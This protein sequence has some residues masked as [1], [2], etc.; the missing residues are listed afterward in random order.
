MG[1]RATGTATPPMLPPELVAPT[2]NATDASPRPARGE[3]P[4]GREEV[5]R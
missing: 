1:G 4:T 2:V 5:S 3:R